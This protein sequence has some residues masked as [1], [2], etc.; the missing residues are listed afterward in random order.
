M[1]RGYIW[2]DIYGMKYHEL[3]DEGMCSNLSYE[4]GGIRDNIKSELFNDSY[5]TDVDICYRCYFKHII[6][7]INRN[8]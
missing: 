2:C 5:P 1:R 8:K 7:L 3:D 4:C 6:P